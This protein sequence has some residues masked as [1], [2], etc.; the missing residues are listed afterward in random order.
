M[1]T[2]AP[3]ILIFLVIFLTIRGKVDAQSKLDGKVYQ[4]SSSWTPIEGIW[5]NEVDSN[6]DFSKADGSFS[7]KF[8][9]KTKGQ[10]VFPKIGNQNANIVQDKYGKEWEL[11]N[12]KEIEY[13]IIPEKSDEKNLLKLILAPKGQRDLA[14]QKYYKIIKTSSDTKLAKLEGELIEIRNTLGERDSL[15]IQKDK[16]LEVYKGLCDSL[17]LYKEAVELASINL[18]GASER[19]KRYKKLLD[20]GVK[21]EEARKELNPEKAEKE[22]LRGGELERA[23]VNEIR[24]AARIATLGFRFDKAISLYDRI[25]HVL[26]TNR[27]NIFDIAENLTEVGLLCK[28][29]GMD[30]KALGYFEEAISIMYENNVSEHPILGR[31]LNI[32]GNIFQS[33]NQYKKAEKKLLGSLE[34]HENYAKKNTFK[35]NPFLANNL[36]NLGA[37]YIKWGRYEEAEPFLLKAYKIYDQFIKAGN[38]AYIIDILAIKINLGGLYQGLGEFQKSESILLEAIEDQKEYPNKTSLEFNETLVKLLNN[39]GMSSIYLKKYKQAEFVF[40]KTL[41]IYYEYFSKNLKK[42]GSEYASTLANL[43]TVF[44]EQQEY[45][46]AEKAFLDAL[47]IHQAF[48]TNV[49]GK[50]GLDVIAILNKL[51]SLYYVTKDY[52][53]AEETYIKSLTIIDKVGATKPEAYIIEMIETKLSLPPVYEASMT[54]E[55]FETHKKKILKLLTSAKKDFE[56]YNPNNADIKGFMKSAIAY[57]K[58]IVNLDVSTIVYKNLAKEIQ[59]LEKKL[60][61]ERSNESIVHQLQKVIA[62]LKGF[63]KKYP[64]HIY[65]RKSLSANYGN[66]SWY[67]LLTKDFKLSENSAKEG[68]NMDP[69]QKWINTNL[70]L[71]L[72]L[73]DKYESGREIYLR[74]K[75]KPYR[76]ANYSKTFLEDI[77]TLQK[78]GITHPD[79]KKIVKLLND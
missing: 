49:E 42:Y 40:L 32:Q 41:K 13:V 39:L 27:R 76:K 18:D 3:N 12:D 45:A 43:G 56:L 11:I 72:I 5:V 10:A 67:A 35:F 2:L 52:K 53:K 15:V 24:R 30:K 19:V 62:K 16:Q 50:F 64:E 68:L 60:D 36:S 33:L 28:E 38:Q 46:K 48:G 8:N 44:R 21:I 26:K 66:L 9:N 58:Y 71:S 47:K 73:Q 70:A 34:I 29:V 6:G 25:T 4:Q 63:L 74:L 22:A 75:D 31:A 20:Q 55:N 1:K 57:E 14:A 23:S 61:T 37:L 59:N 17:R 77:T 69:S 79:F 7:L 78:A 54:E 65:A 51:G